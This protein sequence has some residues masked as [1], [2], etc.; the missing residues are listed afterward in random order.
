[1]VSKCCFFYI[2]YISYILVSVSHFKW[3]I[4]TIDDCWYRQLI[5]LTQ[6]QNTRVILQLAVVWAVCSSAAFW[7]R[8][9][10]SK[11]T[12][13]LAF[14]DTSSLKSAWCVPAL[15]PN[16]RNKNYRSAF[17]LISYRVNI[18]KYDS[19]NW[20]EIRFC[21]MVH[22]KSWEYKGRLVMWNL[23]SKD[24]T[25]GI[26]LLTSVWLTFYLIWISRQKSLASS[27]FFVYT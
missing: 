3:R 9:C 20:F 8:H 24:P 26:S 7:S 14:V 13:P 23:V 4:C 1:M 22:S 21:D 10:R 2:S 25:H 27:T 17:F 19:R 18:K 12:T 11:A 16:K 6:A 5:P 15:S